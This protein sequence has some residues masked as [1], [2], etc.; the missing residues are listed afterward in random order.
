M[1]RIEKNNTGVLSKNDRQ[2]TDTH[3]NYKGRAKINGKDYW[4]SA[5]VKSN[6]MGNY[7]SLSFE[8]MDKELE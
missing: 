4:L 8:N 3:P 5:W 2:T 1:S 6:D 7:L